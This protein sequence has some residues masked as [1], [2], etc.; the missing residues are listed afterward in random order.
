MLRCSQLKS[1]EIFFRLQQFPVQENWS[2]PQTIEFLTKRIMALGAVQTGQ[3]LVD[4][5]SYT[6][7][8]QLDDRLD[9]SHQHVAITQHAAALPRWI[10]K[11]IL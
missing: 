3:F 7:V 8:V 2:G 10:A 9:P 1:A 4:C 11:E 6:S 5:E